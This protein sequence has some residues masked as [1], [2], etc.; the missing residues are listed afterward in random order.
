MTGEPSLDIDITGP[1]GLTAHPTVGVEIIGTLRLAQRSSPLTASK[2]KSLSASLSESTR[3][4]AVPPE[5]RGLGLS[6]GHDFD[7]DFD[8]D[9]DEDVKGPTWRWPDPSTPRLRASV[10]AW[11]SVTRS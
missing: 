8:S 10:R 11:P 4:D 6:I 5:A 7:P 9:F 1:S 3:H 2:S